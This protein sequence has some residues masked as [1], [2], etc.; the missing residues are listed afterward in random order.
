MNGLVRYNSRGEFNSAFHYN[1]PGIHP[2]K[3][4]K[5]FIETSK[6]L[7]S[8]NVSFHVG[9]FNDCLPMAND[10]VYLDPPYNDTD[11]CYHEK[12][13]SQDI[14]NYLRK[15]EQIGCYYLLSYDGIRGADTKIVEIP[16][17]LYSEH[18]LLNSGISGF[19]KL[20]KE[21]VNV[22]E[23]LYVKTRKVL[24]PLQQAS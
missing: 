3:L 7:N 15:L 23:S 21:R 20:Q 4:G 17:E 13:D 10:C 8:K 19:N 24:L 6:L 2:D 14:I 1:R 12:V 9:N 22:K 18:V 16:K 5:I 11:G